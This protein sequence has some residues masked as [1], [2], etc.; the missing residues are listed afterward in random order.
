LVAHAIAARLL[1]N[2]ESVTTLAILDGYPYE[3]KTNTEDYHA[4][5]YFLA[6]QLQISDPALDEMQTAA[7]IQV[8]HSKRGFSQNLRTEN[9]PRR[10][11]PFCRYTAG[12]YNSC[13]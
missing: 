5:S 3:H 6:D 11:A 4:D 7:M 1:E 2:A 9:I 10:Y 12:I 13:R 8:F